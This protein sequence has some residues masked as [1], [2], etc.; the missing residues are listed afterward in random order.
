LANLNFFIKRPVTPTEAQCE[1]SHSALVKVAHD[2]NGDTVVTGAEARAFCEEAHRKLVEITNDFDGDVTGYI[3]EY[4]N[5]GEERPEMKT[6]VGKLT[7]RTNADLTPASDLDRIDIGGMQVSRIGY[8]QLMSQCTDAMPG[9]ACVLW[10]LQQ[11]LEVCQLIPTI[12]GIDYAYTDDTPSIPE[13]MY[14]RGW[15]DSP[16]FMDALRRLQTKLGDDAFIAW[17]KLKPGE[18][19]TIDDMTEADWAELDPLE[20]TFLLWEAAAWRNLVTAKTND[21]WLAVA[22][23]DS[24]QQS[25]GVTYGTR[26]HAPWNLFKVMTKQDL[27][28]RSGA[29]DK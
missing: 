9:E 11:W 18:P 10:K 8:A 2:S 27:V 19:V 22:W 12:T 7:I 17:K 6:E 16:M 29:G 3:V 4:A 5:Q 26:N 1:L 20:E 15:T 28:L 14:V 21:T 24:L 23:W 13:T 25:L